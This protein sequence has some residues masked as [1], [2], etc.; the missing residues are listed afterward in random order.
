MNLKPAFDRLTPE[1]AEPAGRVQ[2]WIWD[3][4]NL[5]KA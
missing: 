3:D 1:R 5:A 2:G 4:P